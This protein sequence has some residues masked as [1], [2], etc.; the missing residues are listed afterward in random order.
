MALICFRASGKRDWFLS[1]RIQLT[2]VR[3]CADLVVGE[4]SREGDAGDLGRLPHCKYACT[5]RDLA[6]TDR[7]KEEKQLRLLQNAVVA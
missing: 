4:H 2:V 6:E 1:L 5:T 7:K 3:F